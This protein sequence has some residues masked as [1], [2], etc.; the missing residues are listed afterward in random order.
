MASFSVSC[1]SMAPIAYTRYNLN[2]P[3]LSDF[4]RSGGW[5][6]ANFSRSAC[7]LHNSAGSKNGYLGCN[8]VRYAFM[9]RE[10]SWSLG[11]SALFA[12][13]TSI[14]M[15]FPRRSP[16]GCWLV[17]ELLRVCSFSGG[18]GNALFHT[19]ACTISPKFTAKDNPE[20]DPM[21]AGASK[22]PTVRNSTTSPRALLLLLLLVLLLLLL[23]L[24]SQLLLLSTFLLL[25]LAGVAPGDAADG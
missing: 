25:L 3:N 4:K 2:N 24:L 5:V 1:R 12:R 23:L 15:G 11:G 14:V 7:R 22:F 20:A 6:L 16:H 9:T 18:D 17:T 10:P 13:K 19:V 21:Y 8:W